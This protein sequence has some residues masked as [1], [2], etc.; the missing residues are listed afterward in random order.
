MRWSMSVSSSVY[1]FMVKK[2]AKGDLISCVVSSALVWEGRQPRA[3]PPG[4]ALL[5][6]IWG[7]PR[8]HGTNCEPVHK[9]RTFLSATSLY[10]AQSGNNYVTWSWFS[11]LVFKWGREVSHLLVTMGSHLHNIHE[12]YKWFEGLRPH[13][14]K[15][16]ALPWAFSSATLTNQQVMLM[17]K[18]VSFVH[19]HIYDW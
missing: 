1:L 5:W 8:C 14:P 10:S 11:T 18:F 19:L 13:H 9:W 16:W 17:G 6:V 12:L 3:D 2:S 7:S 15:G 4:P